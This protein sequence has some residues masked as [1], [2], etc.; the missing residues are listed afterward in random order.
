MPLLSPLNKGDGDTLDVGVSGDFATG[1][2][3]LVAR[4]AADISPSCLFSSSISL[5]SA[6][7]WAFNA[8]IKEAAVPT[9]DGLSHFLASPDILAH[10][11]NVWS[12]FARN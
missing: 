5:M 3:T 12:A 4:G 2:F 8:W 1:S 11:S 6:S 9:N 10:S 7:H